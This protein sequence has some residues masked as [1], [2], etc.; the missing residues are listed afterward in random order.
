MSEKGST[1]SA[2]QPAMGV[3]AGGKMDFMGAGTDYETV[4]ASQSNQILG[5]T[6]GTGDYL[7]GLLIIPASTSPG[8]VSIKD[9]NGSS[10][11][12]FA[13]G[14]SSVAD[15]KPFFVLINARALATTTPG[16][17]VTTGASVS[18]FATGSFT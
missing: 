3:G 15:L 8:A 11:T 16:W 18:V 17:S 10:I 4:A 7:V 14:A 12:V 13:G 9:G 1:S 2:G 5:A 6:G